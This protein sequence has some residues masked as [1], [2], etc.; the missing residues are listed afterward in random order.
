MSW[1]VGCR[2]GSDPHV[3]MVVAQAGSYSSYSTSS[4]GPSIYCVHGPKK[5]KK[6][7]RP[8]YKSQVLL[9]YQG[10]MSCVAVGQLLNL[11]EHWSLHLYIGD[12]ISLQSILTGSKFLI[13]IYKAFPTWLLPIPL[14]GYQTGLDSSSSPQAAPLA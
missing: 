5:K 7:W 10:I 1:H 14:L 13:L 9:V 4:L 12:S 3:A 8:G 11:S 2:C 6:N